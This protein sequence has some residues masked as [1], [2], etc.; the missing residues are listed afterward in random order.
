[1]APISKREDARTRLA[2][3]CSPQNIRVIREIRG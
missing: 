2:G 1:M 3:L